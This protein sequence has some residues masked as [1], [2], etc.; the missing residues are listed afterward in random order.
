MKKEEFARLRCER[1]VEPD[2]RALGVRRGNYAGPKSIVTSRR[3]RDNRVSRIKVSSAHIGHEI[4]NDAR[5][6]VSN[7]RLIDDCWA[8]ATMAGE[9]DELRAAQYSLSDVA[10]QLS[11]IFGLYILSLG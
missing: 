2:E 9:A 11:H 6:R 4:Q 3:A 8:P 1:P 7:F 10:S 5:R